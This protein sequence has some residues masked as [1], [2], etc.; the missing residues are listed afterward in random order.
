MNNEVNTLITGS[1]GLLGSQISIINSFKPSSKSLNLLNYDELDA[2][3]IRHKI[4]KI[5]H[6]A[7]MVGGIYAN[8]T[9]MYDFFS[10]NLTMNMNVLKACKEHRLDK[11]IF[12]LSTC[13]LP[14]DSELPYVEDALHDGEPHFTNYG[15]AYSKRMLE[16]GS[17]SLKQQYGINTYCL[18]PCNLYGPKDNY[19]LMDGHV[20]PSLIHKCYLAK[21]N[22]QDFV[23]W[24]SGNP[25]REFMYADDLAQIIELI[26]NG[27]KDYPEK[28]IISPSKAYSIKYIVELI[29]LKMNFTGKII[30]DNSKPDGILKKPTDTSLFKKYFP[31]FEW[32]D[33]EQ[34]LDVTIKY[35]LAGYPNIRK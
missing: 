9:K 19:N 31:K 12:I 13:I 25:E 30:F 6:C 35:F 34:G 4:D 26:H 5:I 21:Q 8:H 18:I 2:Y 33:I 17:R 29:A 7:A 11:S 3:I 22:N 24:G 23:V 1:S 10:N 16:V 28:M 27:N 15:Y 20:I 14:H 32:K